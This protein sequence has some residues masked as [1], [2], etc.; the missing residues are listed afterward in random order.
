M[1]PSHW[2]SSSA[3]CSQI[4]DSCFSGFA[5]LLYF[6]E[7]GSKCRGQKLL[8]HHG[9]WWPL[10]E[11]S[12]HAQG[13]L[14]ERLILG[15]SRVAGHCL[16]A[17]RCFSLASWKKKIACLW[18]QQETKRCFLQDR[19]CHPIPFFPGQATAESCRASAALICW[20]SLH[21]GLNVDASV[22]VYIYT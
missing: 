17:A 20:P 22:Q 1:S 12:H 13:D 14:Q 15:L 6:F 11:P 21:G 4:S 9:E 2:V 5:P 19:A 8:R 3:F 18:V 7:A 16:R 10:L